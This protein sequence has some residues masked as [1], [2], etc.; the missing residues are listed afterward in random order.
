VDWVVPQNTHQKTWHILS[1]VVGI[2][3]DR[4]WMPSL[5]DVGHVISADNVVNLTSLV[6]SGRL[7]RGQRV[8]LLMAGFGLNWQSLVLQ[9][10]EDF[11]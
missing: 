5:P 4:V 1:R 6:E 9:A 7:R 3:V 8:L 11:A 2:D 10:T